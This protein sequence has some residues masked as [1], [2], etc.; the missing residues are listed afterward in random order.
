MSE[1]NFSPA[2]A[3][4]STLYLPA[5]PWGTVLECLCAHF[6]AISHEQWLDRI[7][8]GRV[9]DAN[10]LPIS[11]ALSYKEGLRIHYF[12]E[13]LNETPI[14]VLENILYADEH[15][16]V[17]DKPHFLPV[18]PAGEY[19]E[20]TLLRRLI[21]RLDNPNLV[22][23]HRIDRHTAGLVLFSANKNSR[24][25]YQSL[26]PTRQINKRYEAIARA[27]PEVEFPQVHTSRLVAAEPFF[28]MREAEG[29][30]NTETRIEVSERN[31]EFWRYGLY[32][33]TGKKHQLR[34]HMAALGAPICND[35]FYPEV[36]KTVED[37][38]NQ[39]LKLLAQGLRFIDPL[40]G[41]IRFFETGIEL[42]W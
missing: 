6:S 21:R 30:S 23:L 18:T 38:F 2:H 12:R 39:P 32:P 4:A 24:S 3:Q 13:V 35:P 1:S 22:P 33:V 40:S 26:F 41:D 42:K 36:V 34:V 17:A 15:L 14:P 29:T 31:G 16:V 9:L 5:G 28:R 25:A 19:V 20:Q 8:R 37:D 7:A 10:G 11:L 27:L